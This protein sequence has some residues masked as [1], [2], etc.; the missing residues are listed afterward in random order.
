MPETLRLFIAI[1]LPDPLCSLLEAVQE[2]LR[3]LDADRVIRWSAIDS[4]HLTL[5]FLGDVPI[6]QAAEV[7]RMMQKAIRSAEPFRLVVSGTGAFPHLQQPR[8]VW[9]GINGDLKSLHTL[10]DAVELAVSPLGFPTDGRSFSPHL[11]LGRSRAEARRANL[12]R[13][14][15]QLA[16]LEI[17]DVASWEVSAISLIRSD[18]RPSGAQY[19]ELAHCP[20]P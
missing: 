4:V 9:A 20:F 2:R 18:L 11:T 14:G 13:F 12:A 17:G 15:S 8:T 6:D 5:K 1:Q 19:T 7:E 10:R 16:E 3:Y